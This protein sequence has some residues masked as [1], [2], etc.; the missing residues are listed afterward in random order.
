MKPN[1]SLFMWAVLAAFLALP[2][3]SFFKTLG[4]AWM[5]NA[6][7]SYGILIPFIV[8]YMLW[9]RRERLQI[10]AVPGRFVGLAVA[11]FGCGLLVV[12]SLS[13]S[14]LLAGIAWVTTLLGTI[15]YIWGA[16]STRIAAPPV[17]L[18]ILMVPLPPYVTGEL[19]WNLQG[20]ASTV[21]SSILRSLGTPVLQ[22][23]NLLRLPNYAL[24][25]KNACSGS[26]SLFALIALALVM[27]VTTTRNWWIRVLLVAIAPVLAVGANIFRIVGTGLIARHWGAIAA[28]ESLHMFWGVLVFVIAVVGLVGFQRFLTWATNEYA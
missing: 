5:E 25:V 23:G 1:S 14:L 10:A 6:E 12:S 13:A 20:L 16:S 15:L 19:A 21:S 17:A 2:F 7:F 8:V 27:G 4:K 11:S 18:T 26:R 24:E 22:E 28:D 9:K 3:A